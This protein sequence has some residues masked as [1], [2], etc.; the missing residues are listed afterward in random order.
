VAVCATGGS[1]AIALAPLLCADLRKERDAPDRRPPQVSKDQRAVDDTVSSTVHR[2]E[3]V[4]WGDDASPASPFRLP[5]GIY[6]MFQI[7]SLFVMLLFLI[8]WP[9]I[10]V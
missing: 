7:A 3:L 4:V 9:L 5:M 1:S 2:C 8:F 10:I 6:S